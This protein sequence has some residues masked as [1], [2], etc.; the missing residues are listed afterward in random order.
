MTP[1]SPTSVAR[2]PSPPQSPEYIMAL[3]KS[4]VT[5]DMTVTHNN[6]SSDLSDTSKVSSVGIATTPPPN[7]TIKL[8]FFDEI[9]PQEPSTMCEGESMQNL[10]DLISLRRSELAE[11]QRSH[12]E[13][14]GSSSS[15]PPNMRE[16]D[17]DMQPTPARKYVEDCLDYLSMLVKQRREELA[18]MKKSNADFLRAVKEIK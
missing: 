4:C 3:W 7:P 11:L 12:N 6:Y 15:S 9:Y 5:A 16:V 1:R 8:Q 10:D 2:A 14:C 17:I 13:R 18:G